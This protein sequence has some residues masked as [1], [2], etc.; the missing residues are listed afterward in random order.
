MS[1]SSPSETASVDRP[2]RPAAE[3]DGDC[4]EQLP[5]DTLEPVVVDL[6]Q[7]QRL[8]RDVRG[9]DAG[10]AH[11]GDV[12]HALEDPVRDARRTTRPACDLLRRLVVDLDLEDP[13]RPAHDRRQLVGS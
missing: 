9:D 12:A 11:L 5:V 1:G 6:E 8:P 3:L 10:V 2:D 7:L 4:L 13:R